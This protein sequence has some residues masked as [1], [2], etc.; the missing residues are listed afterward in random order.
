[1]SKNT[2]FGRHLLIILL[3]LCIVFNAFADL[4]YNPIRIE[5]STNKDSYYEGEKITFYIT[6]T[7]TDKEKSYPVLLPHTQNTG[8]KLFYL[9]L[10]DKANNT[11]ILRATEDRMLKMLVHDT[12]KVKITYLNPLEKIVIPIY[13]N[14]F[15]NNDNYHIQNSAHHSFGVPVFAGV[16][17]I[18][19]TYNPK[20]IALGDSI[21]NYHNDNDTALPNNG[22]LAMEENG[23]QSNML[24]LKVKRSADTLVK[25]EGR[26]YFI[27]SDGHRFYYLSKQVSQIVTDTSCHHI[28]NLPTDSC[29]LKNEYFYSHF[30]DLYAEAILRFEDGDIKEY[31]KYKDECPDYLYTEVYNDLKQK[32]LYALQMHDKQFYKISF[33]Q[34]GNKTNQESYCKS[35][36]TKCNIT[37]YIYH[38]DGTFLRKE[39]TQTEP[40]I[41]VELDGKKRSFKKMTMEAD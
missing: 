37:T 29:S 14:N 6:I 13:I 35:N 21:Y 34:P 12:G 36:G 10:Y 3:S 8:Q 9:N 18:N 38:K 19:V 24:P 23:L 27:K 30:S 39:I 2:I 7:N 28:T 41:E 32:T 20:G 1:M 31:R 11:M 16:Y 5:I 15:E 40:C 22:K 25:I 33:H 26:S 4:K 17:K